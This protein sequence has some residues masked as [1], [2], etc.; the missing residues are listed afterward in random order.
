[1][2]QLERIYYF[3][4][5]LSAGRYPN[6]VQLQE[7]FEISRSTAHRDIAY[8]R[9]RL[10]AP[11]AFDQ[12][13]NGYYYTDATFR[14]PFENSPS[15]TLILGMLGNMVRESGLDSLPELEE[16]KDR[17]ESLVFP[18]QKNIDDLLHCEWIEMEQVD[19][20]VFTS[21]LTALGQQ[22]Q[23][24]LVYHVPAGGVSRRTVDPIKLINYQGRW[25]LLAWCHLRQD[26]RMFHL[27]RVKK[28][29][30]ADREVQHTMKTGD[31]WLS[32][33]FG[34]FKGKVTVTATVRFTGKAAEIVAN[35]RWHPRQR[36]ERTERGLILSLPVADDR[37]LLMKIL[38][39]GSQAEVLSP[40]SLR[41][42]VVHEL[43][44]MQQLYSSGTPC[45]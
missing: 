30:P 39:F 35:Q 15:L 3:H 1:M 6:T 19:S 42:K 11:L 40:Q 7:E 4:S 41:D 43:R 25:Y 45:V 12:R 14:L 16:L 22:R 26:R 18:G 31:T 20:R 44:A 8:L 36:M 32:E 33:S 23:L 34:I 13:K 5:L 29:A 28:A 21:V 2:S 17:L 10:L 37:E 27:G 24:K 38:Q 9:D